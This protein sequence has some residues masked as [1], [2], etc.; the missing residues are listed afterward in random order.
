M[1]N[2]LMTVNLIMSS[3]RYIVEQVQVAGGYVVEF[4]EFSA[5]EVVVKEMDVIVT[6]AR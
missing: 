1:G 5:F 2:A 3:T 4:D 6:V